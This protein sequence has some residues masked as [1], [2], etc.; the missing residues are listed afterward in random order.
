MSDGVVNEQ[1]PLLVS[2]RASHA[3]HCAAEANVV[4]S[5]VL[6]EEAA[7][8]GDDPVYAV[9]PAAALVNTGFVVDEAGDAVFV[10]NFF[11][12]FAIFIGE[13]DA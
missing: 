2:N 11:R 10:H 3:N 5:F 7:V 8:A 1:N 6:V 12:I 4:G 13:I 9:F